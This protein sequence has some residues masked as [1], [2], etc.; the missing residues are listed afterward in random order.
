MQELGAH[1]RRE[2]KKSNRLRYATHVCVIKLSSKNANVFQL[3]TPMAKAL[4][5]LSISAGYF[6]SSLSS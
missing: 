1:V 2:Q 4:L 3:V 5:N 6:K